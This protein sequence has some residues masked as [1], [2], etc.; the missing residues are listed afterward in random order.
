MCLTAFIIFHDT[1]KNNNYFCI[2]R[3]LLIIRNFSQSQLHNIYNNYKINIMTIQLYM[4]QPVWRLSLNKLV[5]YIFYCPLQTRS[6]TFSP[7]SVH[8]TVWLVSQLKWKVILSCINYGK[9]WITYKI[10]QYTAYQIMQIQLHYFLN[11]S[12]K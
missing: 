1:E 9:S 2:L 10:I 4:L 3:F 7:G 12:C 6:F 11:K 8:I 5:R